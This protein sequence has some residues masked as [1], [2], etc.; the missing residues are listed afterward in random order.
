MAIRK[1][2]LGDRIRFAREARQ[3]SQVGLANQLHVA[4]DRVSKWETGKRVPRLRTLAAI[5]V[6]LEVSMDYLVRGVE[7]NSGLRTH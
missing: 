6:I 4:Q 5:A 3:I 2:T 7:K 1:Q